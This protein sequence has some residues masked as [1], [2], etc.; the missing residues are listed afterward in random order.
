MH[1]KISLL[2]V[3]TA[4]ISCSPY[5]SENPSNSNQNQQKIEVCDVFSWINDVTKENFVE[6]SYCFSGIATNPFT[7][8]RKEYVR[9]KEK[10]EQLIAIK[11]SFLI[12]SN[13]EYFPVPGGHSN[14]Y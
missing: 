1:K 5:T 14:V 4:L 9:S 10:Y 8:D 11:N 2:L 12:P 3:A 7:V 13:K 6:F